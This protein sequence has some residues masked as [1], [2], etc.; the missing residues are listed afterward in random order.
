MELDG[1]VFRQ[2][3]VTLFVHFIL[4]CRKKESLICI[5]ITED[6]M[7]GEIYDLLSYIIIIFIYFGSLTVD[8]T[9]E[10]KNF[11]FGHTCGRSRG[12][13]GLPSLDFQNFSK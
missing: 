7:N 6:S 8:F 11:Y 3:G 9:V 5:F 10:E 12:S 2:L 4:L 13:N 1:L